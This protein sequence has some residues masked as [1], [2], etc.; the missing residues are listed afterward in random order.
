[1]MAGMKR[2]T[3]L[4]AGPLAA[5][6]LAC[7]IVGL[8]PLVPGYSHVHQTVSEIGE[9]DSPMRLPFEIMLCAVAACL[10]VFAFAVRDVSIRAG[11]ATAAA[12]LIGCLGVSV[13]GVG[14]FAFP[15]PLHNVFGESELIGYQAPLALALAWRRDPKAKGLVAFS[16]ILFALVWV[17]IALN[18]TILDRHGALFAHLR[19]IYGLVQ[20]A[21]FATALGWCAGAGLLLWQRDW[22]NADSA[23]PLKA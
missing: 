15:H 21:L 12:Y 5:V 22:R 3:L 8:A 20:R 6:L 9:M 18:L 16:W 13:A 19:P 23:V 17:A 1:M 11:H 2:N 10:F 14:I 4:L 7:A